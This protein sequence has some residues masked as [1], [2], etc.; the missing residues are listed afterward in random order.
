MQKFLIT[1][2]TSLEEV[3]EHIKTLRELRGKEKE[4][5]KIIDSAL[6][7][8]HDFVVNLFWEEA[9]T[10]QHMVMNDSSNEKALFQM[11][12]SI[13]KAEFY[14][15]KYKLIHWNSKLYRF[16][17]RF[18]DYKKEYKRAILY[19]KKA[20]KTWKNDPDY[21]EGYPRNLELEAFLSYSIIMSGD[22]DKGYKLAKS[23]YRKFFDSKQGGDLKSKDYQTWGIWVS[24]ITIRTISAFVDKKLTF[25]KKEFITW[26]LETEKLLRPSK[27]FSYR[28][29][30]IELLKKKLLPN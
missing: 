7:F 16:K 14:I 26:L 8:G 25:N 3:Y 12:E 22:Y 6:G 1:K 10:Y 2:N 30:E 28:L 13:K 21:K 19:Y 23:T 20:I 9:L 24:G 17:G 15:K 5:L 4:V 18:S 11:Q 29:E 27:N